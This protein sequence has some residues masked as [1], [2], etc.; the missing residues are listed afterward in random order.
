MIHERILCIPSAYYREAYEEAS[1]VLII[2]EMKKVRSFLLDL[3]EI[4]FAALCQLLAWLTSMAKEET[5][6]CVGSLL[7][8]AHDVQELSDIPSPVAAVNLKKRGTAVGTLMVPSNDLSSTKEAAARA[9][10][11]SQMSSLQRRI[12]DK[13]MGPPPDD[14]EADTWAD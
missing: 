3:P 9:D 8:P 13:L 5:M 6:E 10:G 12:T 7:V 14:S 11:S 4:L 2:A 1:A